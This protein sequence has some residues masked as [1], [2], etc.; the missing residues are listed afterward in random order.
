MLVFL[1]T[2]WRLQA[3]RWREE[4]I[5]MKNV[6]IDSLLTD[7]FRDTFDDGALTLRPDLTAAAGHHAPAGDFQHRI[8]GPLAWPSA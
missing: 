7:I 4:T 6:E 3:I 2:H 1:N 8:T 5:A